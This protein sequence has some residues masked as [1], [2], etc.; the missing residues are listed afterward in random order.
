MFTSLPD[1]RPRCKFNIL[2]EVRCDSV[3]HFYSSQKVH[4]ISVQ[5]EQEI[6]AQIHTHSQHH[7]EISVLSY[8]ITLILITNCDY[9]R[10]R[11]V[12]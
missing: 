6:Q 11:I 7:V 1:Y 9:Y 5:T 3:M 12:E 2:W 10:E 4:I 8:C